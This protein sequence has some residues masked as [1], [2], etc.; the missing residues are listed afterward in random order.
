MPFGRQAVSHVSSLNRGR[1]DNN[2]EEE[3]GE[4]DGDGA[5]GD[6]A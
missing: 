3:E 4:D 6:D 5:N 2:E 1:E